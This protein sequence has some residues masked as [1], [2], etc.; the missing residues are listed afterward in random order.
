MT[1]PSFQA[2][3]ASDPQD[4]PPGWI[5]TTLGEVTQ[6]GVDQGSPAGAGDFTYIDIS[7]VHSDYKQIVQPKMLPKAEAPSRAR[8]RLK[9]GDVLVSMT[10]PNLNA[11]GLVPESLDGAVGSTGFHVLRA[12]GADPGWLFYLVQSGAFVQAMSELVQ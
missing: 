6:A 12:R 9:A 8:Q 7:S 11:V 3:T 4:L 1:A 5:I 2:P 10:R